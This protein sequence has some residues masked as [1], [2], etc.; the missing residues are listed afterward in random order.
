MANETGLNATGISTSVPAML[1]RKALIARYAASK[2]WKLC[3]NGVE[4]DD[5][6]KGAITKFGDRVT[7]QVMPV[8]T[9]V[10]V[11]TTDGSFTN[12]VVSPTPS[13]ITINKWK[14]VPVD[15]VDIVEAQSVLDFDQEFA[16]S[17]G[18]AISEQQD[19]DVLTLVGSL[20]TSIQGDAQGFSDAKTILAQRT[21]DDLKV[22]ID[23]RNWVLAPIAQADLLNIDK[24]TSAA[25]TGYGK[26]LQVENGRILSLYGTPVTTTPLVTT[27]ASM[28]DNVLFHKQAFGIVMQRDFKMEKLARTKLSQPYVGS[29]LYGV[30]IL[31][32][33]HAVWVK[34]SA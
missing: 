29:A 22:P 4:G 34:S 12:N 5:F 1:R 16:A 17:F 10:N 15:I 8:L 20:T 13:T 30:G 23:E 9:V 3:L 26:G 24:F 25:M 33:N 28:R 14:A 19:I 6:V 27:T 32:D 31:R 21:L 2:V 11:S 7:F 18:P